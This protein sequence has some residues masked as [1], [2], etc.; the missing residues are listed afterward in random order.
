MNFYY[1][2]PRLAIFIFQNIFIRK[3]SN[4]QFSKQK[5]VFIYFFGALFLQKYLLYYLRSFTQWCLYFLYASLFILEVDLFFL[6]LFQT[7]DFVIRAFRS[8][9]LMKW[10][11]L[12]VAY[13]VFEGVWLFRLLRKT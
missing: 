11:W 8:F 6:D 7:L 3:T 4:L 2:Q 12:V 10:S 5:R 9:F 1:F 13:I